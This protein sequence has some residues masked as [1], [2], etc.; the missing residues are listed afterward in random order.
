VYDS[1]AMWDK[2]NYFGASLTAFT[3]LGTYCDYTLVYVNNTGTNLFFVANEE[4]PLNL[5]K[6]AGNDLLLW[7]PPTYKGECKNKAYGHC[8]DTQNRKYLK[9]SELLENFK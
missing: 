1:S 5:F 2:T 3:N 7:K 9:S 8:D 6:N 4:T